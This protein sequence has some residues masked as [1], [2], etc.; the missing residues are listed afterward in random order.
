MFQN[1]WTLTKGQLRANSGNNIWRS[2]R[3]NQVWLCMYKKMRTQG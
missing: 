1:V 3:I 2:M